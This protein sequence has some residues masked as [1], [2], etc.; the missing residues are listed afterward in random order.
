MHD[1]GEATSGILTSAMTEIMNPEA[2]T[3]DPDGDESYQ[4]VCKLGTLDHGRVAVH[5]SL[6]N[7]S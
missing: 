1:F 4:R 2:F 5:A 7:L 3:T 6:T